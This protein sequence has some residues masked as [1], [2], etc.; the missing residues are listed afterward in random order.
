MSQQFLQRGD[1]GTTLRMAHYDDQSS[2]K[3]CRRELN[4]ADLRWSDDVAGDSNDEEVA[5]ALVK[6]QFRGDA[7][8]RATED[9]RERL[10][11]RDQRGTTGMIRKRRRPRLIRHE[12]PV[13][14]PKASQSFDCS[15]HG[16]KPASCCLS[17]E[18]QD[19]PRLARASVDCNGRVFIT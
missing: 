3:S 1:D 14:V 12:S 6:D 2:I 13:A 10:L 17:N 8:I 5:E 7:G 9:D 11:S 16:G 18:T 19:Q 15:D 4:A